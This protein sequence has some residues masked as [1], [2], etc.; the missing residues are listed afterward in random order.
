MPM[1]RRGFT[2]VE[3][4]AALI[5]L[6]LL[7]AISLSIFNATYVVG[8]QSVAVEQVQVALTDGLRVAGEPGN[9]FTFP[10]STLSEIVLPNPLT[11]STDRKSGV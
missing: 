11:I 7:Y 8:Q 3:M 4:I 5:M 6:G 2:L 9:H 10:A 1:R